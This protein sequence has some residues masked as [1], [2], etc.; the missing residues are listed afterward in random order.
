[1]I[2]TAGR[3]AVSVPHHGHGTSGLWMECGDG[4]GST[5][6]PADTGLKSDDAAAT[7]TMASPAA[8]QAERNPSIASGAY[9]AMP[10]RKP[11][12]SWSP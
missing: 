8:C 9:S 10:F 6:P 2:Q 5:L 12:F 4:H 7:W 1:M 11:G 3:I